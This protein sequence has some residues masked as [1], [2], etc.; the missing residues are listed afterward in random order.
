MLK[1][2]WQNTIVKT[3]IQIDQDISESS[4]NKPK[5]KQT[6]KTKKKHYF[7]LYYTFFIGRY[8]F[9]VQTS[10]HYIFIIN[11]DIHV[12]IYNLKLIYLSHLIEAPK[13]DKEF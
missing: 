1:E 12:N 10:I 9:Y 8:I 2:V 5:D 7:W 13:M 11:V 3:T 4:V 6:K